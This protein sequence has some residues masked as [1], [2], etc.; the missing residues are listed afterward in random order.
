MEF[1]E[2]FNRQDIPRDVKDAIQRKIKSI[3]QIEH[4]LRES[5]EK[6]RNLVERANDGIALIQD[7]LIKYVNP[8]LVKI[9][10]Y[11]ADELLDTPFM[12]YIHPDFRSE[13]VNRYEQRMAGQSISPIY[14]TT[15]LLKNDRVIE[16]EI[17][18]GIIPYQGKQADLAI[19]RDISKHKKAEEE[20]R[21][22]KEKYQML[23]EKLEEGVL[24]EDAKGFISFINPKTGKLLGYT[25]EELIGKH[26][27]SIV[28]S[29]YI[30]QIYNET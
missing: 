5:E 17:N 1:E 27:S 8:G 24:L 18:A 3:N 29:E 22:S 13:V 26:W 9:T 12:D 15:F 30:D 7:S 20:L 2:L 11:T 25:K 10:G 21:E 19:I 16:V 28:P 14:E 6:Y 23:V 4:E